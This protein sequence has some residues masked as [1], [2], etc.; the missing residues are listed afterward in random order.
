MGEACLLSFVMM[1]AKVT[2]SVKKLLGDNRGFDADL[3]TL[4]EDRLV[5]H[6]G[7]RLLCDDIVDGSPGGIQAAVSALEQ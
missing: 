4:V 1:F 2:G 5:V 3:C 7:R 6:A